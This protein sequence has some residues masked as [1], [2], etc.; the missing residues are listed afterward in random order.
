MQGILYVLVSFSLKS[1]YTNFLM[2]VEAR[3]EIKN[4]GELRHV[5]TFEPRLI[6]LHLQAGTICIVVV[7][8]DCIAE[9][10]SWKS[11]DET[12]GQK[13]RKWD[14]VTAEKFH[15]FSLLQT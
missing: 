8:P 13:R 7:T 2:Q 14:E 11:W 1:S 10:K 15:I 6:F 4:V 5:I 12:F 9:I 3:N